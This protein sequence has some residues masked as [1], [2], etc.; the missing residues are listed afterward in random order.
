[1]KRNR[2]GCKSDVDCGSRS[3]AHESADKSQV[4]GTSTARSYYC[5]SL[6]FAHSI[7]LLLLLVTR[8]RQPESI[9]SPTVHLFGAPFY[10][11]W[12]TSA[13]STR[14]RLLLRAALDPTHPKAARRLD[15]PNEPTLSFANGSSL[16]RMGCNGRKRMR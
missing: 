6:S 3:L 7:L 14:S 5:C 13:A 2:K 9:F 15:D 4:K 11:D 1:M 10:L 12:T 8:Q 16:G